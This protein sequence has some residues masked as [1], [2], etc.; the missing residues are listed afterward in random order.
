MEPVDLSDE[1][2][3]IVTWTVSYAT[4]PGVR[5]PN[6]LAIVEFDL[7]GET[8]RVLGG[9]TDDEVATGQ[10]VV[11][12]EVDETRDPEAGIRHPASQSWDG[13]RFKPI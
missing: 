4:P 6:P 11:A 12:V 10:S 2:G 13:Y 9:L 7:D 8:V 1:V 5:E 3:E